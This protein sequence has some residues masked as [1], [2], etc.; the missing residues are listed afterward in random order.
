MFVEG[1][2]MR[3]D[4]GRNFDSV[5]AKATLSRARLRGGCVLLN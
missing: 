2:V 5:K 1:L 4:F 3:G